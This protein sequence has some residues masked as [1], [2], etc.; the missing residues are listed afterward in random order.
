MSELVEKI[1]SRGYWDVEIRPT[2]FDPTRVEYEDLE[3]V[4]ERVAVRMRGW[5]VPMV[6][7]QSPWLRGNDWV[8]QDVDALLVSH[9]EAWRFFTSGQFVQLRAISADWGEHDVI[10]P[11]A[12]T[13]P[14]IPVWEIL[15][16][17]TEVVE[18]AARLALQKDLEGS[19]QL[20]ARLAGMAERG[21]VVGQRNR[22]E[23][24]QPYV[25][26]QDVLT[27]E[28]TVAADELLANPREI[29]VVLARHLF[30][31]FGWKPAVEQLRGH[32]RELTDR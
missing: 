25:Q 17:L 29:A 28:T 3:A 1:R 19:V 8:G 13:G 14:V 15:F 5:P 10:A 11:W 22:A 9:L 23:F 7:Y 2:V 27:A 6:D 30:L 4:I 26:T 16:F 24:F 31:R 32:Q 12:A 18:L 20:R 21:L